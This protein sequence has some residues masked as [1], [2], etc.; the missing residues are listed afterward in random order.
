MP[1]LC[2]EKTDS[3]GEFQNFGQQNSAEGHSRKCIIV[4]VWASWIQYLP[5]S[6]HTQWSYF[7]HRKLA[8]VLRPAG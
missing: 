4:A 7:V 2:E 6:M 1:D 8:I 5:Y 3:S